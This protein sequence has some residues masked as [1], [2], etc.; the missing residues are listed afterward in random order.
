MK[1]KAEIQALKELGGMEYKMPVLQS[2]YQIDKSK[3]VIIF[4]K[5]CKK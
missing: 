5:R 4:I 3:I 2:A 1:E